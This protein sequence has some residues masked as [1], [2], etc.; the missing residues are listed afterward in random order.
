MTPKNPGSIPSP[1]RRP[2]PT[3][4]TTSSKSKP[5]NNSITINIMAKS[6]VICIAQN[7]D[8]AI[9]IVTQ[10]KNANF[11]NS[12]ISALL[13]D[14]SGT[15]DFAHEQHTKAPEGATTGGVAGGV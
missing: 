9:N 1:R 15:K 5:I 2:A 13:P 6:S 12:D 4:W 10:L 3:T 7:E 8:Q 11:S 14:K